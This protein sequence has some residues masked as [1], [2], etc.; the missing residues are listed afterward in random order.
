MS[1]KCA[2]YDIYI[3]I[4][5]CAEIDDISMRY[6]CM[7]DLTCSC[8]QSIFVFGLPSRSTLMMMM[9][10]MM[11]TIFFFIYMSW[12]AFIYILRAGEE[13]YVWFLDIYHIVENMYHANSII[14]A[15]D[16]MQS[17]LISMYIYIYIYVK[18]YEFCV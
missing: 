12:D 1:S 10:M 17:F 16:R 11:M 18:S 13:S 5:V 9:M 14:Y 15:I 7:R 6:D 4:C 3:Y 8:Q 2:R